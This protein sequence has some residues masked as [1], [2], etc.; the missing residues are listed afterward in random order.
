MKQHYVGAL[1][2]Y[3]KGTKEWQIVK[4]ELVKGDHTDD[5]VMYTLR[6]VAGQ[7]IG[8]EITLTGDGFEG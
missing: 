4:A 8:E 5:Q 3:E 7:H 1:V 2:A 6:K